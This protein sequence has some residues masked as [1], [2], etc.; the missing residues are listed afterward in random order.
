MN[1]KKLTIVLFLIF[2]ILPTTKIL[3][4]SSD[5]GFVSENIWYSEDSFEEGDKIRIYTFIFN[6]DSRELSG[7][8]LF[9][10]KTVLLGKKDFAVP[11]KRALDVSIDWTVVAGDHTIFGKIE[12]AKFLVSTGNYEQASISENE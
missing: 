5:I 4:Q 2:S 9:F 7:T 6:P 11:P 1:F 12:D 8:V 3:A 10:D